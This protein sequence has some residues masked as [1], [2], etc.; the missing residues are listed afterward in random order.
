MPAQNMLSRRTS[1][2]FR[3]GALLV[4]A[5][6][7]GCLCTSPIGGSGGTVPGKCSDNAP[8]VDIQKTD[9][10]FVVD[11]S[12]SMAAKQNQVAT[13]LPAFVQTLQQGAG[14]QQDFQIGLVTTSVYQ[15]AVY[16]PPPAANGMLYY[17]WYGAQAGKLQP[18]PASTDGGNA[19]TFDG[20]ALTC[21]SGDVILNGGD[22]CLV[23]KFARL[24]RGVGINGSGQETPFEA[25]RLATTV[26][27]S[28]S[29]D[30][31]GNQG[32]LRDGAQLLIVTVMD[33]DDCSE[34]SDP[35]DGGWRPQ[36][37]I[38]T[39]KN[40][41]PNFPDYCHQ[42]QASLPPVQAYAN[43]FKNLADSVG[44]PRLVIWADI[45][46]VSLADKSAAVVEFHDGGASCSPTASG[47]NENV[48]CPTS[49]GAG[50]RHH[51][52]ATLFDSTLNDLDS[53]CLADYGQSLVNIAATAVAGQTINV[54]GIPDPSLLIVSIT[55]ANGSVQNCTVDGTN[56]PNSNPAADN[57]TFSTTASGQQIVQF[58]GAC[59]R[60]LDDLALGVTLLC[61]D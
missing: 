37:Y 54:S 6:W 55:R 24:I 25:A 20:G 26:W 1:L 34:F 47:T 27:N 32:F 44:D 31:G 15:N 58:H 12:G 52:L 48:D 3:T 22:P 45:G 51:D 59:E 5:G 60:R 57:I 8:R 50:Y 61:V 11:N 42:Q 4:W 46:P 10:L 56:L 36:V 43:V 40:E 30:A 18:V 41:A 17:Q 7:S 9:I 19:T 49:C 23:N 38:G 35:F 14:V 28:V 13:D 21:G 39:D 29:A 53:I 16:P 2:V 33:E